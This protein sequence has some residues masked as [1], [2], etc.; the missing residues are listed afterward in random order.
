MPAVRATAVACLGLPWSLALF[1]SLPS[2]LEF[3]LQNFFIFCHRRSRRAS[4]PAPSPG[5]S[6]RRHWS[7]ALAY[8]LASPSVTSRSPASSSPSSSR[9]HTVVHHSLVLSRS[10][11]ARSLLQC[12]HNI[13]SPPSRQA[14]PPP[15]PCRASDGRQHHLRLSQCHS[16][17]STLSSSPDCPPLP[18]LFSLLFLSFL[19]D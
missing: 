13:S 3:D 14:K 1:S 15:Q 8:P 7:G 10:R 9:R 19:V 5:E 16:G 11:L 12:N 2:L 17:C 18:N 6:G 4:P